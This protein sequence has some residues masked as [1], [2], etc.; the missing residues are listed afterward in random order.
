MWAVSRNHEKK[1]N[2]DN[3]ANFVSSF[4]KNEKNAG[5]LEKVVSNYV[6]KEKI[7]SSHDNDKNEKNLGNH[8]NVEKEKNPGSCESFVS[9]FNKNKKKSW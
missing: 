5:S 6:E 1:K 2:P 9:S 7:P 8:D 4:D 3:H